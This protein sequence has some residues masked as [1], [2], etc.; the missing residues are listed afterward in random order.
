MPAWSIA[1]LGLYVFV[2]STGV[3]LLVRSSL[4][5]AL[6]RAVTGEVLD[7]RTVHAPLPDGVRPSHLVLVG[8]VEGALVQL[9]DPS[10]GSVRVGD[11]IL[12]GVPVDRRESEV[13]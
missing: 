13:A 3:L 6:A 8:T 2:G 9:T 7:V 11:R 12:R 4:R 5:S 1:I 10:F